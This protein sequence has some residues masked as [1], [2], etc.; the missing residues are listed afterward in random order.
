MKL[1]KKEII[2]TSVV[3]LVTLITLY[4]LLRLNVLPMKYCIPLIILLIVICGVLIYTQIKN[5]STKIGKVL[6]VLVSI[7]LLFGDYAMYKGN[8]TLRKISN[9][10]EGYAIV[11]VIV[12]SDNEAEDLKGLKGQRLGYSDT[13]ETT[14]VYRALS[15]VKKEISDD[16]SLISYK[17]Y[18][19][20]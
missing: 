16:V 8:G 17:L 13:G 1:N 19:S 4:L 5:K 11:S 10:K 7:L 14:Y 20:F 12:K 9:Q 2:F 15:D 6:I 3:G 18:M